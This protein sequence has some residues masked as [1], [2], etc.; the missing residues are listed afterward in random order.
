MRENNIKQAETESAERLVRPE[1]TFILGKNLNARCVIIIGRTEYIV[2]RLKVL[3]RWPLQ[4]L[5]SSASRTDVLDAYVCWSVDSTH[6]YK[7]TTV[8]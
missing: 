5:W 6:R 2:S 8:Y 7:S 4:L 3:R 1:T